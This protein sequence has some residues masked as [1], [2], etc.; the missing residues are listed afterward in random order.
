MIIDQITETMGVSRRTP[1]KSGDPK[2]PVVILR[3]RSTTTAIIAQ[4][5][6]LVPTNLPR[7]P[8][9]HRKM[10]MP[11]NLPTPAWLEA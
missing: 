10:P 2:A 3:L 11:Y 9:D 7:V 6:V 4:E 5:T 8:S 1:T